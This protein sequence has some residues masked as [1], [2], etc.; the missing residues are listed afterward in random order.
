MNLALPTELLN[1]AKMREADRRTIAHG[2]SGFVLMQHAGNA[3]A[4]HIMRHWSER[5]VLAVCGTGNNGG[6]GF[7]AASALA[8]HGWPVTVALVGSEDALK[9][10][11]LLAFRHWRGHGE[12]AAFSAELAGMHAL[13]VDALFGTGLARQVAG[14]SLAAIQAMNAAGTP[15]IAVDL[16]SGI[17][18]DSGEIMGEAVNAAH[19]VTFFR[20]HPGHFLLPGKRHTGT[21]HVADIGISS[22]ILSEL[23]IEVRLNHPALWQ[24]C[25]PEPEIDA[26]KYHRG[27][28][29]LSGGNA[30]RTGATRLAALAALKAGAGV[31]TVAAE[32]DALPLYATAA[33]ALITRACETAEEFKELAEQKNITSLVIGPNHGQT[34]RTHAFT[35]AALATGKPCVLDADSLSVFKDDAEALLSALHEHCVITP[36]NGEYERLFS[37]KGSTLECAL[38]AARDIQSVAVVKGNDTAIADASGRAVINASAPAWLATA[39]AGDVL[40]GMIGGLLAQ[41]MPTFEAA[42]AGVW[43]HGFSASLA[44]AGVIADDLPLMVPK[45]KAWAKRLANQ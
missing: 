34:E 26:H 29:L 17:H 31:V 24:Q 22:D 44:G 32:A 7:I 4:R 16:P 40:A 1:A 37:H 13:I 19:T 9:G 39:G 25:M 21:L 18:A 27:H 23:K 8:E 45:A 38:K 43:L 6:D 10:D 41:A 28:C 42:A 35:L 12:V 15:V 20:A 14:E 2:T 30:T 3:V 36:H 11:A 33:K 5:P